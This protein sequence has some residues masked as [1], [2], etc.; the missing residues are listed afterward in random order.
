M[1]YTL[2]KFPFCGDLSLHLHK[3]VEEISR[4]ITKK[5]LEVYFAVVVLPLTTE[6]SP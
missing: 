5:A 1:D 6:I 2:F 4:N 3:M